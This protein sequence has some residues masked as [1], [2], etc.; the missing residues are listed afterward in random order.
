MRI[1]RNIFI[2]FFVLVVSMHGQWMPIATPSRNICFINEQTGWALASGVDIRVYKTT[3]AGISWHSKFYFPAAANQIVFTDVNNGYVAADSGR[4]FLTSNGG[5]IWELK[6]LGYNHSVFAFA[7]SGTDTLWALGN[8][9]I[10]SIVF[11]STDRGNSWFSIDTIAKLNTYFK[12][13]VFSDSRHGWAYRPGSFYRTVDGGENWSIVQSVPVDGGGMQFKDSLTGWLGCK[14][15]KIAKT[16]DGGLNWVQQQI[17]GT[18]AV[19]DIHWNGTD[20]WALGENKHI[21]VSSDLGSS[22]DTTMHL[23]DSS[24]SKFVRFNRA[25]GFV[26][27]AAGSYFYNPVTPQFQLAQTSVEDTIVTF[28]WNSSLINRLS[29]QYSVNNSSIWKTAASGLP[30]TQNTIS[31]TV[32][33]SLY[34]FRFVDTSRPGTPVAF[35][36]AVTAVSSRKINALAA[37]QVK[38]YQNR[39]AMSQRGADTVSAGVYWPGGEGASNTI[40]F[41]DGLIWG[42]YKNGMLHAGRVTLRSGMQPGRILPNGTASDPNDLQNGVYRIKKNWENLPASILKSRLQRDYNTWPFQWGAPYEDVNRDGT[43][44]A[45]IDKPGLI[46]DETLWLIANDLNPV[47]T[48]YLFGSQPVGI[49][50]RITTFA[51]KSDSLKNIVFKKYELFNRSGVQIDSLY[52]G[53]WSDPNVDLGDYNYVGCDVPLNLGYCYCPGFYGHVSPTVGFTILQG[54]KIGGAPAD[55][56]FYNWEWVTGC[57]NI[58]MTSFAHHTRDPFFNVDPDPV[59]G[60]PASS[61]QIYNLLR[62]KKA[63]GNPYINPITH[64]ASVYP[65]DGDPV[66]YSGWTDMYFSWSYGDRRMLISCG[67]ISFAPGEKQ[68]IA[69]AILVDTADNSL[70]AITKVKELV[71]VAQAYYHSLSVS[72]LTAAE[73]NKVTQRG[74]T[75]EQNYPNPF[76][77]NTAINYQLAE[78]GKVTLKVYDI[79]GNEVITLVNEEQAAG[80]HQAVFSSA[81]KKTLASG[82][83]FYRLQAGAN[84]VV[85]KMMLM[86]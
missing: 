70:N 58:P 53:S 76:N 67:P 3:D 15:G 37:N 57:K 7:S 46:G 60:T 64:Q 4:I 80:R 84:S 83:Y 42:G 77:P 52:L 62:G 21:A 55:S 28:H 81:D 9:A 73:D 30:P 43:Y 1:V 50:V 49:E 34:T 10:K 68:E 18:G 51:S 8:F 78:S 66:T 11:R 41:A 12:P 5:E 22:W 19:L 38:V 54:P 79:L 39:E 59:L 20:L 86:K 56:A 31:L 16:T 45:G 75:L 13:L 48:N 25:S 32:A 24:I 27:S 40:V 36:N 82:V 33:D 23:P 72:T 26:T 74:F 29:I 2:V 17:W 6:Y 69:F 14:A 61:I 47:K 71:P 65:Y 44:N 85:K 35:A 63:D